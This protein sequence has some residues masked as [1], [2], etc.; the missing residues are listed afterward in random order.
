MPRAGGGARLDDNG[1]LAGLDVG[2]ADAAA[3]G[4]E[5]LHEGAA[6]AV[7]AAGDEDAASGLSTRPANTSRHV[8]RRRPAR[9]RA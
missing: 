2:E 7:G 8:P 5:L 9:G 3:L 6:N 1:A 4:G